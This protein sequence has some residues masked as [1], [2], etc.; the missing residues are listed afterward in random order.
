MKW[1][2][3]LKE[4]DPMDYLNRVM[5]EDRKKQAEKTPLQKLYYVMS[6]YLDAKLPMN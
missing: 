2:D 6:G 4:E 5:A 3:V 1:K